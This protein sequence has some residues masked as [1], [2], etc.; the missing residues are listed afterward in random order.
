MSEEELRQAYERMLVEDS[1]FEMAYLDGGQDMEEDYHYLQAPVRGILATWLVIC[2]L[3]ACL[4][5]MQDE[6]V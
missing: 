3:A 4:Y 6:D 5:Y 2:G 1:L